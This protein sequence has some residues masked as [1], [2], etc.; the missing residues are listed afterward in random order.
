VH[1]PQA[2]FGDS[3]APTAHGV[4]FANERVGYVYGSGLWSTHD[5]GASW[6]EVA[7]PGAGPDTTVEAV[8]ASSG[9]VYAVMATDRGYRIVSSPEG[10]DA[11]RL[12]PVV[13]PYGAGPVPKVQLVVQH[14]SAWLLENDRVVV[15]GARLTNGSWQPWTPPC[16]TAGG[17]A[18]L[19]AS[20]PT[21][22]VAICQEGIW[23]GSSAPVARQHVS[24][25]GGTTFTTSPGELPDPTTLDV[26][27]VATAAPGTT[28]V[29]AGSGL[30]RTVDGGATWRRVLAESA[31]GWND[32]GFTT[33]TQGIAV[34]A[35][36]SH[37]GELLMTTDAGRTWTRLP[38][39]R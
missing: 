31:V 20:S 13:V 21:D 26:S 1:P 25:D 33:T 9:V 16:L 37:P 3:G 2:R 35:P 6:R 23:T 28:V 15:G 17:P 38:F 29:A 34:L 36:S 8:E 30:Y 39:D 19:A 24:T 18:T 4:R 22:L 5:G 11:W 32:V 10:R 7:L 12:A 27:A 14:T